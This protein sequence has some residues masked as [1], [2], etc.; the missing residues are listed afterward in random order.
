M[1]EGLD[2]AAVICALRLDGQGAGRE[3]AASEID[4]RLGDS[5]DVLWVHLDL[6]H[7]DVPRWMRQRSGLEPHVVE[8]LVAEETRPRSLVQG[9]GLLLLLR[10]VNL[11]PGADAED[12]VSIRMWITPRRI[13]TLRRRRLLAVQDL[14]D[15]L[16]EG[17]GPGT[18]GDFVVQLSHRLIDRM[19]PEVDE[20]EEEVDTLEDRIVADETDGIR[21]RL[22]DLRRRSILLRRY[23]APQRDVL[24]RLALEP[25]PI[26]SETNRAGMREV[27]DRVTRYVEDLDA[28]R[29]RAAV[30][31]DELANRVAERMNRTMY[32]LSIVAAIFLPLGLVTGLL[33]VNVGGIPGSDS[34]VGFAA[35]CVLLAFL[36]AFEIWLFRKL[37]WF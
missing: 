11:N 10:G 20:I 37:K 19:G 18:P 8:A 6:T 2:P 35:L 9:D 13:L 7:P 1:G 34:D 14:R 33:G 5:G 3:V 28:V 17:N 16:A 36:A 31:Q 22:A 4:A 27:A 15:R 30:A 21:S 32:V 12:M 29:E 23:L 24:A 25:L 26:F